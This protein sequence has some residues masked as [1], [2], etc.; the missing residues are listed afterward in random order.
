MY[1]TLRLM[2]LAMVVVPLFACGGPSGYMKPTASLATPDATS[3]VVRFMRPSRF[4]GA[5]RDFAI[6][7]GEKAIGTLSNGSQFGYV[8]TPGKHLFITPGLGSRGAYFLEADLV[9]GKTY[10]VFVRGQSDAGVVRVFLIPITRSTE[11]WNEVPTYEKDLTPREPDRA[12]LEAWNAQHNE[13]IKR[14]LLSYNEQWKQEHPGA[15]IAPE[16]G[17]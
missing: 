3:A 15:K 9:P 4:V 1:S 14:L 12:N 16:D 10:Y 17:V 5:A 2:L 6:L 7:D 13:E 8:T 11:Q